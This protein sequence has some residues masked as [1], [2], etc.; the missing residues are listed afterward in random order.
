MPS[1]ELW[2][3]ARALLAFSN[4]RVMLRSARGKA[5][6]RAFAASLS[7]ARVF[8][9]QSDDEVSGR[10][11]WQGHQKSS[12]CQAQNRSRFQHSRE[13]WAQS[14]NVSEPTQSLLVLGVA[15]CGLHCISTAKGFKHA[16]QAPNF[17][18]C[19]GN[20]KF[21]SDAA[22]SS[23]SSWQGHQRSSSCKP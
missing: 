1:K 14:P 20:V 9:R 17:H 15:L 22:V 5:T 3:Q 12:S 2:L 8:E 23:R 6:K 13:A 16:A 4:V 11:S 7:A 21:E 18:C 19:T 10:S